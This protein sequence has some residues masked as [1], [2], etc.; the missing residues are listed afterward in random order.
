MRFLADENLPGRIVTALRAAGAEQ[1]P[2]LLYQR[3][4]R[5]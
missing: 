3:Y 5:L 1:A 2:H 4:I